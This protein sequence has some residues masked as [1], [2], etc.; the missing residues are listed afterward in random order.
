MADAKRGQLFTKLGKA[1]SIAAREGGGDPSMNFSLRLAMDKARLANMPMENV[2]RAIKRGTGEIEGEGTY[3]RGVYGGYGPGNVPVVVDVLT[4]NKNRTVSE[5]RSI[6]EDHGGRLADANS[7]LWQFHEK[8][9]VVARC[10]KLKKSEMFGKEDVE[11]EVSLDEVMMKII[12]IDGVEDVQDGGVDEETGRKL[13]D[14][15]T[16]PKDLARVRD[17]IEKLG[18]IVSSAEMI[19]VPEAT[20]ELEKSKLD[21]LETLIEALNEQDDVENVWTTAQRT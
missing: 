21:H 15:L 4:D 20:Q 10:A 5:I 16:L 3:E 19:K 6:F 18:Y 14:I 17:G 7:V 9:L 2:E 1:I 8:G 11:E 12:D 13:C